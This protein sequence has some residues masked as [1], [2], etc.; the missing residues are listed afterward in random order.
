M[1]SPAF[2]LWIRDSTFGHLSIWGERVRVSAPTLMLSF[3]L[4]NGGLGIR[5]LEFADLFRRPAIFINALAANLL[6]PVVFIFIVSILKHYWHS[7][8]EMQNILVGLA[9]IASMPIA[10]SS[11]AWSQNANGNLALSVGLVLV[12]TLLSPIATPLELHTV[13]C[14]TTGDYSNDLHELAESGTTAFLTLCVVLPVAVGLITRSMAGASRLSIVS[15]YLKLANSINLLLLIYSNAAVSLPQTIAN[16]DWDFL[17]LI[18]CITAGLCLL[19]FS[20]GWLLSRCMRLNSADRTSVLFA[21]GMNNN[22]T[23]LVL[24]SMT[25]AEHPRVLL[26]IIFYN[27]IQHLAAGVV[28]FIVSRSASGNSAEPA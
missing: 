12:S 23:S 3:L 5:T 10:G 6:I 26:P 2:G 14:M 8:D 13:G 16:P 7:P 11:T 17:I 1:F 22:G 4:L 15:P 19:M 24:A 9:L 28:D 21:L 20:S 25:L 18:L 27:L